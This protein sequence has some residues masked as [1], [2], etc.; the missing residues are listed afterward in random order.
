ML[1][2]MSTL[3]A[4]RSL[5]RSPGFTFAVILTLML[6]IASAGAMF[7]IVHGVLLAPLP[8]GE[9]ERLV[10]IGLQGDGQ[11]RMA[12]PP[13]VYFTYRRFA[14]EIAEIGFSRSGSAN[15]WSE[16]DGVPP[17]RVGATWVTASLLPLLRVAPMLGRPFTAEETSSAGGGGAVIL[18]ESL[19]RSRFQGSPDVLGRTILVNAVPRQIVGVMPAHFAYPSA[20]T[21]LW[22]PAR[23]V[24]DASVGE[25]AYRGVARLAAGATVASAQ[26]ELAALL[27][28]TALGYPRLVSGASTA[29]WLAEG[30]LSPVVSPLRDELTAGIA[31]TLWML[32]AAAALVLLVA[33]ANVANLMLLRGDAR[34]AELALRAT[35]GA[36]RLRLAA[37]LLGE[38]LLL[39]LAA[40]ALALPVDYAALRALVAFGPQDIPRLAEL[41][42]AWPSVGFVALVSTLTVLLCATVPALRVR[43]IELTRGLHEGARGGTAGPARQRLR[44]GIAALQIALALVVV[45]G[46]AL[47]LRSA[48]RLHAVQ[49]G[50]DASAVTV[51]WTGLPFA[52]YDEAAAIAFYARLSEQVRALPSVQAAGVTMRVPLAAGEL[53][54]QTF[55][56]ERGPRSLALAVQVVDAGYFSTMRIPLLAGRSFERDRPGVADLVI[57][58]AAAAAMFGTADP[59]AVLGQRLQL[60]PDGPAY[61]IVGVAGDVRERELAIAPAPIVY[62]PHV[63]ATVANVE[64]AAP[65]AM[66]LVVRTRAASADLVPAVR[67]IVADL[68]PTVPIFNAMAM[69][70]VVAASTARLALTLTLVTAA[71][72]VSLLLGALGLYGVMA[73]MVALRTREFGVRAA[74]GATPTR[75]AGLVARRGLLLT[76]GGI[77]AGFVLHALAAPFLRGFLYEVSASDPATLAAATL[78]LLATAAL[79]SWLPARRAAGVAPSRA[80][81]AE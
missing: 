67:Q 45:L 70:E 28:K 14:R 17:E 39:G 63:V 48:Q 58:R 10:G 73:Y 74:L 65:R 36:G 46:S 57:S 72:V 9:P 76:A 6:G 19:W 12:Q 60:A 66:A 52:R 22:L 41:G 8:Y 11:P 27:P 61:T 29:T 35:L 64:L 40:G 62:R 23:M 71:A 37:H 15:L 5:R 25:F 16:H 69:D 51:V 20:D 80:L 42:L 7:A 33:W 75:I 53:P 77:A 30:N 26:Q 31:R 59:S 2:A 24:D 21:R 32:A 81:R 18:S 54:E 50:F 79:A 49:P 55:R 56:T 38:S 44:M 3:H 78:V 68:D 13:A 47:L 1:A 43:R 34:Q 4:L